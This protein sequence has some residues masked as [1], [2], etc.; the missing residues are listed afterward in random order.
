MVTHIAAI[1]FAN[2]V[3]NNRFSFDQSYCITKSGR[4]HIFNS[5]LHGVNS[6]INV[7][8]SK[9]MTSKSNVIT[10]KFL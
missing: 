5:T 6:V 10:I 4:L 2:T 3:T 9:K 1:S 8:D 7:K